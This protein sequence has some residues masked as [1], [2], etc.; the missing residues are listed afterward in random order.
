M[1]YR[2]VLPVLYASK[3]E[4]LAQKYAGVPFVEDTFTE[5]AKPAAK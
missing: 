2:W 4:R 5:L 3:V 1:K